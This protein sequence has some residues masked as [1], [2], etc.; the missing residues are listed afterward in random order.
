MAKKKQGKSNRESLVVGS[1][2]RAYIGEQGMRM[3]GQ[4]L[5]ALN[6]KVYEIL[7]A[8]IERCKQNGRAT[9]RPHDL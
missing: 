1:K 9:V 6:N 8:A 2:V 5:E 4:L 7:D 3:D